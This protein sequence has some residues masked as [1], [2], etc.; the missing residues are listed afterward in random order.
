MPT[1]GDRAMKHTE[2]VFIVTP[3]PALAISLAA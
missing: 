3:V 2:L 1:K